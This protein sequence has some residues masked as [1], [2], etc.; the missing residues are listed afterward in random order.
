MLFVLTG[1]V[2]TGKT[3]WLH[4]LVEDIAARGVLCEGVLAPGVWRK[5]TEDEMAKLAAGAAT[6]ADA[7]AGL[8]GASAYEKL[9]IENRLLPDG[10]TI[11][12]GRRRDLVEGGGAPAGSQ[13]EKARLGWAISDEA[14]CRVNVHLEGLAACS[15]APV[16]A[17]ERHR[18]PFADEGPAAGF[19]SPSAF[20]VVDELGILELK[21]GGGLTGALQLLETGPT[22]RHP[23]ALAVV[24]S[25]LVEDA[26]AKLEP[27]WGPLSAIGPDE[28]GRAAVFAALGL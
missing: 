20:L 21:R 17:E 28:E 26:R 24:R 19:P 25:H 7:A 18:L 22:A 14:I 8:G 11:V 15:D 1:D 16:S 2:Q 23:H 13:S 4:D 6:G 27:A 9:G 5:R 10:P 3:R 12:F